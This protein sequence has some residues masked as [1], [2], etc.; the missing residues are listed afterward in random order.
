MCIIYLFAKIFHE[1]VTAVRPDRK[2]KTNTFSS[3]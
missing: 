3:N 1:T 2:S